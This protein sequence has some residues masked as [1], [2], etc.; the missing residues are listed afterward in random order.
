M[1]QNESRMELRR[2]YRCRGIEQIAHCKLESRFVGK[3]GDLFLALVR[4][5]QPKKLL[6]ELAG[7]INVRYLKINMTSV[8]WFTCTH[9]DVST[10]LCD[11]RAL[12]EFATE[13]T[14]LR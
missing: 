2:V 4:T 12:F 7:C 11:S 8:S 13:N 3:E 9:I 10:R 1:I 14:V 5:T 6:E